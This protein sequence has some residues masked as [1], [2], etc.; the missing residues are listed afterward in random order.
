MLLT[1][2]IPS[3]LILQCSLTSEYAGIAG[4]RTSWQRQALPKIHARDLP[5]SS[6]LCRCGELA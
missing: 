4:R 5:P 2:A 3:Q 1:W 6:M